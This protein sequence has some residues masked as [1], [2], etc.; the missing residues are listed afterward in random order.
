MDFRTLAN[1]YHSMMSVEA[2]CITIL[3][4][5]QAQILRINK[6]IHMIWLV[7]ERSLRYIV[8][9]VVFYALLMLWFTP[10]AM[11]IWGQTFFSFKNTAD[12]VA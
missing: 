12:S 9:G 4:V 2:I 10:Y 1:N 5:R 6:S 11:S 7:L 8:G 3:A